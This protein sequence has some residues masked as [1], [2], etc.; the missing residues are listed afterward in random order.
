MRYNDF[1]A[2]TKFL[3]AHI[4]QS[5]NFP[6]AKKTG[7]QMRPGAILALPE[8]MLNSVTMKYLKIN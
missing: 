2:G 3:G 1:H 5:P 7:V 6:W 4:S 8:K